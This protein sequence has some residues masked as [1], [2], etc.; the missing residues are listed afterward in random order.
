[1]IVTAVYHVVVQPLPES[2][3]IG[4][5]V[6][7]ECM[8]VASDRYN[9]IYELSPSLSRWPEL[10]IYRWLATGLGRTLI[11][12]YSYDESEG[13]MHSFISVAK[14]LLSD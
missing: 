13:G 12:V 4:C 3:L 7:V 14:R 10:Q 8:N 11:I 2:C 5:F 1:M 9:Y 6:E